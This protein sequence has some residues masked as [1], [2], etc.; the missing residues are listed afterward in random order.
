MGVDQRLRD[1]VRIYDRNK[2]AYDFYSKMAEEAK[3][4]MLGYPFYRKMKDEMEKAE[5]RM[6]SA[7]VRYSKLFEEST[8]TEDDIALFFEEE[9]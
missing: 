1:F 5:K 8:I 2:K 3:Q 6:N 4:N 7:T 9:F